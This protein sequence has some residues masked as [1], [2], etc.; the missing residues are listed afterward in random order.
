MSNRIL[1]VKETRAGEQRVGLVPSDVSILVDQ[2]HSLFVE[3]GAGLGAGFSDDDYRAAGADIVAIDA[4]SAESF[5]KAF[6]NIDMLVR[7]KR[8]ERC[9]E[10]LE[11]QALQPGTIMIGALDPLELGSEHI[12]EYH[13]AGIVAYS[14]DQLRL[15]SDDPM[16]ILAAMSRFAGELAL[17]DALSKCKHTINKVVIIGLGIVGQSALAEAL[18]QKLP[19]T[20]IVAND[21][22]AAEVTALGASAIIVDRSLSLDEQQSLIC[23]SLVDA[24]IVITAARRSGQPAPLLVPKRTIDQM[25]HHAVIVDMSISEGGNVQGSKHDAVVLAENGVQIINESGY[26]K[27][28]PKQA[29]ELWSRGNVHFITKLSQDASS[30]DLEPM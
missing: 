10:V 12:A 21:A 3:A 29:S 9:R 18:S 28:L 6:S 13:R 22:K 4:S 20:V 27:V 15:P 7:A 14:I 17:Q 25:Q 30:I 19:V 11:N 26:P 16:N 23:D 8:P 24:D 5:K 2:G 1:L